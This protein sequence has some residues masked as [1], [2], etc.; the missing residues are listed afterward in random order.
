[1]QNEIPDIVYI[2]P[3][4]FPEEIINNELE[5]I[6]NS[7]L[8]IRTHKSEEN[9]IYNAFEWIIPTAFGVYILK[10]YFEG[11]LSEAGKD[12]YTLLKKFVNNF[13]EKGKEYN[14]SVI[15]AKESPD[16]LSKNYNKSF[17]ISLE[18]QTKNNRVIKVLF[19]NSLSIEEWKKSS[20]EILNIFQEHYENFPNDKLTTMIQN[21]DDK[22]HRKLYITVDKIPQNYLLR[23][24]TGMMLEFKN[25]K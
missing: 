23:D 14:F 4:F 25:I 10:P 15:A 7:N 12:H 24:D 21:F 22:P 9:S 6:Q 2:F 17:T 16:K 3:S 5:I 11:F 18:I 20:D 13:L 1:M 19:D 8:K